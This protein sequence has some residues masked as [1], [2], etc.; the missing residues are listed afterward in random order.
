MRDESRFYKTPLGTLPSSTTVLKLIKQIPGQW[1]A[2]MAAEHVRK[3]IIDKL[4]NEQLTLTALRDMDIDLL[5]KTAKGRADAEK[6][7]AADIGTRM[8]AWIEDFVMGRAKPVDPSL[9]KPTEAFLSW[10]NDHHVVP[11]LS[12]SA[13]YSYKGYAGTLDMVAKVDG[14]LTV[15][16][17]KS[18]KGIYPEMIMQLASYHHAHQEMS[19]DVCPSGIILRLDKITG[20]P[21]VREVDTDTLEYAAKKF[22]KLVE[23]W[24]I[25][26]KTKTPEQLLEE[27]IDPHQPFEQS[28]T[29]GDV[30]PGGGQDI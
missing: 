22:F 14:F 11:V 18:S 13:V 5:M 6:D 3:E 25:C 20:L 4:I 16:D 8:H 15:V 26:H 9:A 7:A 27:G 19:G 21:Q 24:H 2:K 17:F 29:E 10:F 30:L 12:E 23:Y 1:Y 28:E